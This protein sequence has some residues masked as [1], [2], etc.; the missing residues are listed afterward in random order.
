MA[1]APPAPLLPPAGWLRFVPALDALRRYST[2][3][4]RA[5]FVAGLTVATV[6][7]PQAMAYAMAAGVDP[8]NGL[9]SA[10]VVTAVGAIFDSSRQLINGPT[11]ATSIAVLS[12]TAAVAAEDKLAVVL[13]LG[14]MIGT[15]QLAITLLRLGDL[16]RYISHSVVVGFTLGAGTLLVLDQLKNLLGQK[17]VGGADAYFLVRVWRS[18]VEGGPVHGPTLAVG[19]T[20]IG[21]AVALRAAKTRL[22]WPLFP[23]LLFIVVAMAT[24]T[25]LFG[26]DAAGVKVVGAIPASLPRFSPPHGTLE[27]VRA[28]APSA[29]AIA[30]LG[31][32]EALAMAKGIAAITGQRLDLNQQCLSEGLANFTGSF[33][34][35]IPGS[36]SLTRS[37]I[38]QQAGARTQWSGVWSAA[39]VALIMLLFAPYARYIPRSA[40][41]GLLMVAAVRMVD[42]R[43]IRTSVRATRFDAIIIGA[44]AFAAVFISVE[45][46][47]LIGVVLSFGLAV[48]RAGRM[49]LAE[50]VVAP[51]GYVH[52][53][54]P[55]DTPDPEL[56]IFG[57][58]GEMFFAAG[59]A[60]E[61]H[62][63]T[64]EARVEPATQVL[65]LRVKRARNPDAVGAALVDEFVRRLHA[66]GVHVLLCGVRDDLFRVFEATGLVALIHPDHVFREQPVRQTSTAL[67][68]AHAQRLLGR[69]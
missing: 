27:T 31:L 6:A 11:N 37:A 66:R 7:V 1:T 15:I 65:I 28:L 51:G 64:I 29:F 9:F 57:L 22:R 13:L 62:L 32:L 10:I 17:T 24:V 36:G 23:E 53:R 8:V 39:A 3:D 34:Q 54:L 5:D 4:L 21:L 16:T 46:C 60:L 20:S 35:S 18:L 47:I 67:A 14:C 63:D 2:V 44:T 43:T 61:A 48:P 12:A 26:L 19:L 38:N 56:L 52:D 68:V 58:E 25:G 40:L 41:A 42:W 59:P 30:L 50:F 45:F 55:D 33:F 69:A 49:L